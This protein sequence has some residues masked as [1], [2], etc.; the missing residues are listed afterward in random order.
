MSSTRKPQLGPWALA[1]TLALAAGCQALVDLDSLENRQCGPNEKACSG[2]CVP[3]DN[4]NT[5]CNDP[6]CA[7]CAPPHAIATCG[8]SLHCEFDRDSCLGG[9][10]DCDGIS[11]NGCET[12]LAHSALHCGDCAVAC[13]RPD[14][15][16]AGCSNG[17]CV[18][19]ACNPGW[20]DCDHNPA[21][22]C[23]REIWTDQ[24]CLTCDLPCPSG[25]SC[26]QGV[27]L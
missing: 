18:I 12:D 17:T 25:T 24:E 10:D 26:A 23:E 27:C 15:G 11:E 7:P 13:E 22:G 9:W 4:P 21:S 3:N 5:G 20:E 2:K 16:I 19:G 8:Q 14:N 6:G 1:A